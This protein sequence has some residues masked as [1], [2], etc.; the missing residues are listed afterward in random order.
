MSK[1]VEILKA[2]HEGHLGEAKKL[3][4]ESLT[5]RKDHIVES[6]TN[7]LAESILEAEDDDESEGEG[8]EYSEEDELDEAII[9]KVNSKGEKT[10]RRAAPDGYT[11]RSGK[12]EKIS[13]GEKRSRSRGA[14]RGAKKKA[15]KQN[16]INRKRQKAMDKRDRMGVK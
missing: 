4:C 14:K 5:E 13:A 7:Y 16:Q 1:S 15:G 2:L 11:R 6:G 8:D 9:T 12:L 3:V 10:K